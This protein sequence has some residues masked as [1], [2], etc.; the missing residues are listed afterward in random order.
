M[1]PITAAANSGISA[2]GID[3]MF[4]AIN[5]FN[6]ICAQKL[7]ANVG[8]LSFDCFARN[9]MPNEHNLAVIPSDAKATV[10][11]LV[12]L[13]VNYVADFNYVNFSHL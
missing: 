8:N 3:S 9:A 11:N 12:D 2:W 7:L 6:Y 1:L 4:A 5:N 13:Q 10:S